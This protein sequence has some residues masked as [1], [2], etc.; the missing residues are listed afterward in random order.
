MNANEL[1][2]KL[3][4]SLTMEYDCDK[5]MEQAATMLRNQQAEI[6]R[7]NYD[8]DGFKQNFFVSGFHLQIKMANEQLVKQQDEIDA[9]KKKKK[10]LEWK[11]NHREVD[12][13]SLRT[14]L[15]DAKHQWNKETKKWIPK[16]E[17]EKQYLDRIAELEKAKTLTDEEILREAYYILMREQQRKAQEK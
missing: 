6:D 13:D 14:S 12:V 5:Y 11:V 15:H 16:V 7:L 17:I 3:M 2:D 1:A 4:S 8:L 9:L 10:D